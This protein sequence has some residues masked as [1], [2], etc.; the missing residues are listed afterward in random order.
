MIKSENL[1]NVSNNMNWGITQYMKHFRE[2]KKMPDKKWAKLSKAEKEN[3]KLKHEIDLE[4]FKRNQQFI[5]SN[6]IFAIEKN[7]KARKKYNPKIHKS[8]L[9]EISYQRVNDK[10]YT[11]AYV[12][13]I[14]PFEATYMSKVKWVDGTDFK[15]WYFSP[16][17]DRYPKAP[18]R[19]HPKIHRLTFIDD[20][21]DQIS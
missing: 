6:E 11:V 21:F 13:K 3:F 10:T 5:I 7:S 15:S 14:D 12:D 2:T 18:L 9:Q 17:S 19:K 1:Q 8:N 20:E 16:Q 4:Y